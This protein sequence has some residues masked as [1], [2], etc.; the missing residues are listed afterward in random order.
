MDKSTFLQ[1]IRQHL[2]Q[3]QL[4]EASEKPPPTLPLA[5]PPA[6]AVLVDRFAA[7]LE[8]I[9]G[10]FHLAATIEDVWRQLDLLFEQYQARGFLGWDEQ[11]LPISGVY[12]Y[13]GNRGFQRA[14]THLSPN[15]EARR[16]EQND[17][18]RYR[19]GLTGALAAVADSGSLVLQMGEGRGRFASLLP[20]VHIALVQAEQLFLSLNHFIRAYPEVNKESSNTVFIT[21][22]SRTGDIEG[23]LTLGVHGPK[24]LH[25][26]MIQSE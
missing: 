3:S 6:T 20:E 15:F 9:N 21:G 10:R 12:D 17:M 22:P 4:P 14:Q 26:I 16:Q 1:Q 13:L 18:A 19:I 8:I 2:K 25:V 24:Q 23:V 7:E 5:Q 11:Y